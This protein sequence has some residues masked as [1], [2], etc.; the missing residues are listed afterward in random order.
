MADH[1]QICHCGRQ[2]E[3]KTDFFGVVKWFSR[4]FERWTLNLPVGSQ[5]VPVSHGF[6][7][8]QAMTVEISLHI[9]HDA[10]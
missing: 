4:G 2:I 3:Y 7:K 10:V 9:I 8:P 1:Q 5:G 6:Q